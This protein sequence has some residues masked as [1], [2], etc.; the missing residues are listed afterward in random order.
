MGLADKL[1]EQFLK[2]FK[3]SDEIS[4]DDTLV[5][6]QTDNEDYSYAFK[7]CRDILMLGDII[8]TQRQG[9]E[10]IKRILKLNEAAAREAGF[11]Q[12][13]YDAFGINDREFAKQLGYVFE[14]DNYIG[15]KRL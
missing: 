3:K 1:K 13:N 8:G 10:T 2:F 4:V 7:A 12:V 6:I 15:V 11:S 5:V 14:G 9:E